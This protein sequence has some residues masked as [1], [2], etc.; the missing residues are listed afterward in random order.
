MILY[1]YIAPGQGQIT[2]DDKISNI[3]LLLLRSF[4][5]SF[6]MIL[7]LVK[8][9]EA[10]NHF[11]TLRAGANNSNG[12]NFEHHEEAIVTLNICCKFRKGCFEL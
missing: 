3:E 5:C 8:E 6:I 7:Q 4:L 11:C 12:A 2:S 9:V 10:K 1:M